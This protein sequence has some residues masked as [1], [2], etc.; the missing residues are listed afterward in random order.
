MARWMVV[1]WISLWAVP[2][3]ASD[4]RPSLARA[5]KE[6]NWNI[7]AAEARDGSAIA[8][9]IQWRQLSDMDEHVSFNEVAHFI[10]KHP[11]WPG[12]NRLR[13]R[14]ERELFRQPLP[15]Q[16]L[17]LWFEQYPPI[18]GY[19][20]LALARL[21]H[22]AALIRDAWIHGDFTRD[23]ETRILQEFGSKLSLKM[24]RD[25][26]ERLLLARDVSAALRM[27][28][29]V[30]KAHAALY[31][32]RVALIKN[33]SN[34]NRLIDRIPAA[35]QRDD[36]LLADRL[37]WRHK[38]G[39]S[40]GA[41]EL[42]LQMNPQS[43]YG[44]AVWR[45]RAAYIR[46]AIEEG[47]YQAAKQ[48][49]ETGGERLTGVA[50]ADHLWLKGWL[51]YAFLNQPAQAYEAFTSL[52]HAV[53]YPVS[54]AR[55]AYWAARAASGKNDPAKARQWLEQ[56][57]QYPSAFYGQVAQA[58]LYPGKPL[59]L[60]ASPSVD[61]A[62]YRRYRQHP[63]T[64]AALQLFDAKLDYQA[65]PL[66][67]ELAQQAKSPSDYAALLKITDEAKMLHAQVRISKE[68][69]KQNI[70]L[71]QGWP[72]VKMPGDSPLD[73]LLAH[74]IAR[75]E[76]EF[77]PTA[78]SHANARGLMQLLPSTARKVARELGQDY[79]LD[80]LFDPAYNLRLGSAYLHGL[81]QDFD[82]NYILAIAGYNA[83]PSRSRQW[84]QRFGN[85]GTTMEARLQ[86]MEMI[87]FA[88]TRNYVQRVLEQLQLYRAFEK[89]GT[90]LAIQEDLL[91]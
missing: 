83:G 53:S 76:S 14:A 52:Y 35:Q 11:D 31:E 62:A 8:S 90:P 64:Q 49:V 41:R 78:V 3:H 9:Y 89:P 56:A 1:G 51:Y 54:K 40:S 46:D 88:E 86:W 33:D 47:Q 80:Q 65:L 32:A 37:I 15:D 87:P 71:P 2:A 77:N 79:S 42:L 38:R 74:A 73:P 68:A 27:A 19:G 82:G 45:I 17:K 12:I 44:D 29:R 57:A 10:T 34:V 50:Q 59:I 30:D 70:V 23:D 48:L 75:Q 39:L 60:P 5:I 81:L 22:D 66:L 28:A 4:I 84:V 18:S 7:A 20:K 24:H 21:T 16:A 55:G 91:R 13:V 25:R 69:I 61:D 26:A 36:G 58:T 67:I 43:A 85:T 72:H 6:R 63:M